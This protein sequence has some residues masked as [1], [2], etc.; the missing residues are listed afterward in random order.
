MNLLISMAP[1]F[2]FVAHP[3]ADSMMEPFSW[4]DSWQ[5]YATTGAINFGSAMIRR[6]GLNSIL[7]MHPPVQLTQFVVQKLWQNVFGKTRC[8]CR[9]NTIAQDIVAFS[10]NRKCIRQSNES[11]FGRAAHANKS[12]NIIQYS[13]GVAICWITCNLP[14]RNCHKCPNY[15][16]S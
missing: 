2:T 1:C 10:F 8:S 4:L 14:D 3:A 16:W 15:L 12:L 7:I 11:H 6:N 13:I 5:R 9:D